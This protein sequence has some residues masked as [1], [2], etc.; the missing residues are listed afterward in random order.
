MNPA[1]TQSSVSGR[2]RPIE[3]RLPFLLLLA[4]LGCGQS[5]RLDAAQREIEAGRLDDAHELI[6][7]V[8]SS[9]A[10]RLRER[11]AEVRRDRVR[12]EEA[13]ES[14][15][16][17][18]RH[19]DLRS[20]FRA[21]HELGRSTL[22]PVARGWIEAELSATVEWAASHEA[23]EGEGGFQPPG[24]P[25]P[26]MNQARLSRPRP[27]VATASLGFARQ[28]P[29]AREAERLAR[30]LEYARDKQRDQLLN[31]L[32]ELARESDSARL[33]LARV[34]EARW[35]KTLESIGRS[36]ELGALRALAECREK[37]DEAREAAIAL[38][39]DEDRYF[40]PHTRPAVSAERVREYFL[41][42]LE[43][44]RLI[45][46][47]EQL[48][49]ETPAVTLSPAFQRRLQD[50]EALSPVADEFRI[51]LPVDPKLPAWVLVQSGEQR[52]LSLE[53]FCWNAEDRANLQRDK[54][55]RAWNEHRWARAQSEASA[56]QAGPCT[57]S[58]AECEQVRLTNAYRTLMG[59]RALAWNE[60]LQW[61]AR[62]HAQFM[63]RHS[64]LTH[65]QPQE[66]R[67]TP[68]ERMLGAGYEN[69]HAENIYVGSPAALAAHKSWLQSSLHHRN[70]LSE[71][72]SEMASAVSDRYWT[73]KLGRDDG[74]EEEL[75]AWRD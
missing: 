66:G 16:A 53:A 63:D 54:R 42:Q 14:L 30:R 72:P 25:F 64:T 71:M 55:V 43:V 12:V 27:G 47:V 44:D 57:I 35:K 29:V 45:Q 28:D 33:E 48:V 60:S 41:V 37:L 3:A 74:Y 11:M 34:V 70:L 59:R 61:A 69:P 13:L 17:A 39:L 49:S 6:E 22:D 73:Q 5:S 15:R 26:E 31:Q 36:G 58:R 9:R 67:R 40:Y 23:R 38:I 56:S 65:D 46:V 10:R 18:R 1:P 2:S 20:V 8:D 52:S 68:F 75:N 21:L 51:Q 4:V 32:I 62:Q 19:E 7:G 24:E 50:L